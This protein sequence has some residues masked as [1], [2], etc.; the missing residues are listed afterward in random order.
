MKG[1]DHELYTILLIISNAVAVLM[2][3]FAF[4]WPRV[5]RLSFFL[6]FAWASWTNWTASQ[7]TPWFYLD[8]ADLTW[9]RW[10]SYFINGWFARHISTAVGFIA[11]CQVLIAVSML[12]KGWL[13]R[14]GAIGAVIFLLA[15]APF[16][17]GS[18]FPCTIIMAI[19]MVI[20]LKKHDNRFI[21][22]ASQRVKQ[23]GAHE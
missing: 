22:Q 21:W 18:G 4:K 13:F 16:G 14:A 6:L 5:G 19:A 11:A 7:Q 2:L 8:Y 3:F 17:T 20:L 1:L 15:I 23:T 12:L 9:S 10:Y